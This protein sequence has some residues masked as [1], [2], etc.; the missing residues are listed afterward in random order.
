M[1]P[2]FG[3]SSVVQA[4]VR[5]HLV[6]VAAPLLDDH[7]RLEP[8]AKPLQAQALVAQAAVEALVGAVLPGLPGSM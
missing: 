1:L 6:V 3:G 5:S 4:R 7:A 8:G 2:E